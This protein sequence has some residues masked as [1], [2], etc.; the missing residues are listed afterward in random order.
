MT[1]QQAPKG[2]VVFDL[3]IT[4]RAGY[5]DYRLAGQASVRRFGGRIL[6]GEPAPDGVVEC[7][8]GEWDTRR[9]V[10]AEFDSVDVGRRWFTSPEYQRA[11]ALR[12][13]TSTG[14]VLLVE[15]WRKPW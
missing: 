7:L 8:E 14:R 9:L 5:E 1:G 12:R 6:S 15:G 13:A 11:A 10:I 3:E 4:D 2:Y